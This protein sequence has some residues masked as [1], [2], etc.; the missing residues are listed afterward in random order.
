[1]GGCNVYFLSLALGI[2]LLNIA[3][4]RLLFVVDR[5]L[6][7]LFMIS[8]VQIASSISLEGILLHQ[9][10]ILSKPNNLRSL[11]LLPKSPPTMLQTR[12]IQQVRRF[13]LLAMGL[14]VQMQLTRSIVHHRPVHLRP[15]PLGSSKIRSILDKKIRSTV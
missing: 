14:Q 4:A 12:L 3:S 8:V 15:P 7:Y 2:N 11:N 10:L 6:T 1:M 13:L 9:G 5:T